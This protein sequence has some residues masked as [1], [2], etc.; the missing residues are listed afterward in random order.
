MRPFKENKKTNN[1]NNKNPLFLHFCGRLCVHL[2]TWATPPLGSVLLPPLSFLGKHEKKMNE[3]MFVLLVF[4]LY[5]V[6]LIMLWGKKNDWLNDP[7]FFL[8]LQQTN[9]IYSYTLHTRNKVRMKGKPNQVKNTP[10]IL[11]MVCGP[12]GGGGGGQGTQLLS[13]RGCAARISVVWGFW[14]DFCL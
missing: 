10:L 7:D 1:N 5:S 3:W 8:M 9:Y 6:D 4:F 11:L 2:H 12:G 13:G 14:T